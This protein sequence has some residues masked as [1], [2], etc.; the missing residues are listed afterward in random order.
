MPASLLALYRRVIALLTKIEWIGPLLVRLTVGLAFAFNGWG[1]LHNLDKLVEFF[2]SLG[3]PA[4]S[5]QAPMVATIE[6]VGGVLIALGLG[7]RIV[8]LLLTSTMT[9]ALL[10]APLALIAGDRTVHDL[11][12]L[13]N[14]IE[15]TYLVIFLWLAVRGAGAASLDHLIAR[16]VAASEALPKATG[17]GDAGAP[18]A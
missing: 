13:V 9:V 6:C 1:K 14:T 12:D 17:L 10:T 3:I 18:R 8:A 16:R 2:G 11:G 15:L 5:L 7:T 4:A